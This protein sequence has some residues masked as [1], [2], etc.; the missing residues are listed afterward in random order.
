V[1]L[2]GPENAELRKLARATIE[3]AQAIKHR[4]E[5][6]V[7]LAREAVALTPPDDASFLG[8]LGDLAGAL[9][10]RYLALRNSRDLDLAYEKQSDAVARLPPGAPNEASMASTL[11]SI[12]KSRFVRDERLQ[13][14]DEAIAMYRRAVDATQD[15]AY[16]APSGLCAWATP[17]EAASR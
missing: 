3:A 11:A 7:T 13:D 16:A 9:H 1:E 14:L 10:L 2:P 8:C 6:A 17:C 15:D 12:T 5:E 4:I